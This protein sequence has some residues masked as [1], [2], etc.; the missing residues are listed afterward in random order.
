MTYFNARVA[1]HLFLLDEEKIMMLRRFNT[2]YQDGKYSVPA[3]HVDEHEK[4]TDAILRES[5]EELGITLKRKDIEL[6]HVMHRLD[7]SDR[8]DYFFVARKWLGIPKNCEPEKSDYL[9]WQDID[10]LPHNTV[11]YVAFAIEQ[12]KAKL[13]FSEFGWNK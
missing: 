5:T 10:V 11:P 1:V 12:Y 2:G 7:S 3:G 8:I 4:A 6:V 13:T 9:G